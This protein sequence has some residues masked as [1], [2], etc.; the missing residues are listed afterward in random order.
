MTIV[1]LII[2]LCHKQG[3][4]DDFTK[5]FVLLFLAIPILVFLN[6]TNKPQLLQLG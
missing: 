6:S 5:F 2:N 3:Y 1:G 4:K